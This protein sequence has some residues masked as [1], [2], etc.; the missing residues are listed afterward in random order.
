MVA[1]S[2]PGETK[3]FWSSVGA[4]R[5][6]EIVESCPD[7]GIKFDDFCI[8]DRKLETDPNRG[9][10]SNEVVQEIHIQRDTH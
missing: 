4:R 6:R 10:R 2:K 5:V 9:F 7:L 3:A 1:G 8:F